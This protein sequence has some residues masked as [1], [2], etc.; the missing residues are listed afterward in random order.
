MPKKQALAEGAK[1]LNGKMVSLGDSA[2]EVKPF[3]RLPI[4]AIVWAKDSEFSA[5]ANILY[6]A[7]AKEFLPTEDIVVVTNLTV[8]KLV[9]KQGLVSLKK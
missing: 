4:T 8:A 7:T 3:S 9:S 5:E 1:Y 6:D 2:V